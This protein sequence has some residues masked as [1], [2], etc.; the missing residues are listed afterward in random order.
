MYS[1]M[2]YYGDVFPYLYI[3]MIKVGEMSGNLTNAL[4]QAVK[5]LEDTDSINKTLRSILIPNIAQF[6]LLIVLLIVGTLVALPAIQNLYEE[7]GSE[8]QLPPISLAFS[9]FIDWFFEF[10]YIP[11]AIIFA[12]V[13]LVVWYVSTP[14][15]KFNYHHFKYKMPVFGQLIFAIDFSRVIRAMLLN[16]N[17]GMRIQEALEV[18]KNVTK[19]LVMLSVLEASLNNI[20]IRRIM[21][22]AFWEVTPYFFNDDRNVKNRY[23]YWPCTN[24]GKISRIYGNRYQEFA[25]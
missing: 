23:E 10:W 4:E 11:V 9:H 3:N 7:M 18:S 22:R 14:K 2:E 25:W 20:L 15:G 24:D 6:V 5:Y 8:Q 1:T 19:N 21:D 12:I 16:L 17:N 13:A